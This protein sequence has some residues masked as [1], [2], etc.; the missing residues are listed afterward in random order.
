MA[1]YNTLHFAG[2]EAGMQD[3]P[4]KQIL[5]VVYVYLCCIPHSSLL[6]HTAK[7]SKWLSG[8][9]SSSLELFCQFSLSRVKQFFFQWGI[10]AC[11]CV[12]GQPAT[13]SFQEQ[14][15]FRSTLGK[16]W[17][18]T[19]SSI[20]RN[21]IPLQNRQCG[22]VSCLVQWQH[23][24]HSVNTRKHKL[25]QVPVEWRSPSPF[26]PAFCH[27]CLSEGSSEGLVVTY[28]RFGMFISSRPPTL[29]SLRRH[30]RVEICLAPSEV[31]S[32]CCSRTFSWCRREE[33]GWL[34]EG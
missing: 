1:Q 19:A 24:G 11:A 16:R 28:P 9:S 25:L 3:K 21:K 22:T 34:G 2:W 10:T 17:W 15:L 20:Q 8:R 5:Q 32:A 29:C 33:S 14:F 12:R 13:H 30:L 7:S 4:R 27:S 18:K 31:R 23:H 26:P 6:Y